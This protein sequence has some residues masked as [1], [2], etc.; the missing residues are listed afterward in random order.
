MPL[1]ERTRLR[2]GTDV[3]PPGVA[4]GRGHQRGDDAGP[5]GVVGWALELGEPLLGAEAGLPH[6]VVG[7]DDEHGRASGS[8]RGTGRGQLRQQ[9]RAHARGEDGRQGTDEV[10]LVALEGAA[11]RVAEERRAAPHGG[12]VAEDHPQL[13][14]VAEVRLHEVAHA[15]RVEHVAVR[16]SVHSRGP[17]AGSG[18][19]GEGGLLDGA[20]LDQAPV[21][22]MAVP[23]LEVAVLPCAREEFGAGVDCGQAGRDVGDRALEGLDRLAEEAVDVEPGSSDH[24]HVA[25]NALGSQ[26][27]AHTGE[28]GRDAAP[29]AIP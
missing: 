18:E 25:P 11:A 3:S 8:G 24:L 16:D 1:R 2:G 14:A 28:C 4:A 20:V 13:V 22:V 23:A 29:D 7:S 12:A 21:V 19:L 17:D 6:L 26:L 27:T 10:D 9:T 5:L 15:V